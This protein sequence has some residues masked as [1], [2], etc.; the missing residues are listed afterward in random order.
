MSMTQQQREWEITQREAEMQPHLKIR[1]ELMELRHTQQGLSTEQDAQLS[2]A[3]GMV[4]KI[5]NEIDV[6]KA[7]GDLMPS[8]SADPI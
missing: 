1:A 6:L 8:P 4:F 2:A 3:N 5:R 7:G